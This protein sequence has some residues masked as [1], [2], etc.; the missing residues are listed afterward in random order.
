MPWLPRLARASARHAEVIVLSA[1]IAGIAFASRLQQLGYSV[2]VLEAR[3]SAGGCGRI[4]RSAFQ[5]IWAARGLPVS[6]A[7]RSLQW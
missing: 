4:T 5:L 6:M 2:I 7:I 1:G 3:A